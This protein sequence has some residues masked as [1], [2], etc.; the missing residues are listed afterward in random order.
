MP[1]QFPDPE[2]ADE[3]GLLAVGGDL[4]PETLLA[5]YKKGIFPWYE[6]GQP[7]LWWS[8]DPRMVLY[9]E[10]FHCSPS[11]KQKLRHP[12]F[13]VTADTAFQDVIRMCSRVKRK[14]QEGTWITP[15]M[16]RAFEQMYH[17]GFAHSVETWHHGKLA[18]GLYGLAIGRVFYGESMFHTV[19]DSSKIALYHLC[20]FLQRNGFEV[21]DVQ[22]STKHLESLGAVEVGREKFLQILQKATQKEG[23][24]GKWSDVFR[25]YISAG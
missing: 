13:S 6:A 25:S 21:I 17:L 22:Q 24:P 14:G 2:L 3:R 11:L 5:A 12:A 1:I 16:I 10:D 7:I 9:P 19:S 23:I 18:G 4:E 8:P 20:R 15:A